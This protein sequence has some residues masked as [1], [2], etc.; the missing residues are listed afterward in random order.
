MIDGNLLFDVFA[1]AIF[2]YFSIRNGAIFL[3]KRTIYNLATFIIVMILLI[4]SVLYF[5]GNSIFMRVV[6]Y[7]GIGTSTRVLI[8]VIFAVSFSAF[9]FYPEIKRFLSLRKTRG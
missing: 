8:V 6:D 7:L 4:D 9:L 2:L 1:A 3:K 5:S